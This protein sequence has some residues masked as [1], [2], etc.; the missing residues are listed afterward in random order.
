MFGWYR[1]IKDYGSY[2]A[3]II[4]HNADITTA[5]GE[6]LATHTKQ[7]SDLHKRIQ[8][9]ETRAGIHGPWIMPVKRTMQI[10]NVVK[11]IPRKGAVLGGNGDDAA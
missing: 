8:I 4:S 5:H 1:A 3:E 7:L 6:R 11:L 2:L 10:N 9:L